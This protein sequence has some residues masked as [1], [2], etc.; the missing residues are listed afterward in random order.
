M[1]FVLRI[2]LLLNQSAVAV[3]EL[4]LALYHPQHTL[5]EKRTSHI[6]NILWIPDTLIQIFREEYMRKN[7]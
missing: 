4:G 3:Q 5:N 2:F 7:F 6:T 1:Y